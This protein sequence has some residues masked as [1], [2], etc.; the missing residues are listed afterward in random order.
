[1]TMEEMKET[2]CWQIIENT[3]ILIEESWKDKK[4]GHMLRNA[5]MLM[6][7]Y[8]WLNLMPLEC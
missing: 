5:C 1:M 7:D 8:I 2:K 3:D 6:Q 4:A